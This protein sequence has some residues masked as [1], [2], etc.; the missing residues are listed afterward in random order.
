MS[1]VHV[2]YMCSIRY[3]SMFGIKI[4]NVKLLLK[5]VKFCFEKLIAIFGKFM[6]H[7]YS[8]KNKNPVL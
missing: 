3:C 8:W 7:S 2:V 5:F 1:Y 6:D 4:D